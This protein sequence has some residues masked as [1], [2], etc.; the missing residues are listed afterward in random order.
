MNYFKGYF[1]NLEATR[2][3]LDDDG[4][5]RTGDIGR[6]D[7][8][9]CLFVVDRKQE[10][11]KCKGGHKIHVSE[12]ENVIESIEGVETVSVVGIP[13]D[14]ATNLLAAVIVKRHGF[15]TV[16][17]PF[18]ADYVAARLPYYKHLDAGVYFVDK[19]PISL[20][21]KIKKR[22][23]VDIVKEQMLLRNHH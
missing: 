11:I 14:I 17:E 2:N 19:I 3:A 13:D 16:T 21:G 8:T 15:E 6:I 20:T 9:G 22:L 12:I 23:V 7:E 1:N 4:Y 18:V 10:V 5:F